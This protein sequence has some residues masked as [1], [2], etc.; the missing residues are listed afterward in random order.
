M[1][2]DGAEERDISGDNPG[3][4]RQFLQ[5]DISGDNL[6]DMRQFLQSAAEVRRLIRSVSVI[7]SQ[8]LDKLNNDKATHYSS[9]T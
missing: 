6:G 4:M 1:A 2:G 3:D 8:F 7:V 5:S 9:V